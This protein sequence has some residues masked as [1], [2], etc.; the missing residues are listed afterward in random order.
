MISLTSLSL[1]VLFLI[2]G[3]PI[4]ISMGLAATLVIVLSDLPVLVVSQRMVNALDSSPLLAV[5]LFI[6]AASLFDAAGITNHIFDFTKLL[7]GRIRGGLGYVTVLANLIFSGISGAAL[8]DIGGLG[9]VQI[10][11]MREQGYKD[12]F[13]A[14]ITMAAATIG[15]IF[16]PSIP[17]IIYATAAEISAIKLLIAGVVPAILIAAFL[18]LEIA[19]IAKVKGLPREEGTI[20]DGNW[21]R[22]A[23]IAGP[24]LLAPIILIGGLI[25]GYFGP[26]EVA[27][28][29]V[30]YAV[31]LGVFVYRRLNWTNFIDAATRT[32]RATASILFI[33][34]CAAVFAWVFTVEQVPVMVGEM[35]LGVS[36]N[37]YVL[38]AIVN[39]ALLIIG[40]VMES[41]AAILILAP[42]LAPAMALAGVDP[43]QLGLVVVLN[44]MIGLMTPPVGMSLYMVSVVA[45]TPVEKVLRG[46]LPFLFP[47]LLSLVVVS[48]VPAVS[49]WLPNLLFN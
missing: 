35:L 20:G 25:S 5:P 14:G 6:F 30:F 18:M 29:T 32:V 15:P 27:A 19:I 16:P 48:M 1:F 40:M 23:A 42:I 8:A 7:V 26:T 31:L 28:I 43:V 49:T 39:V 37:P 38:L 17:L 4:A 47:L 21:K 34:G 44:L 3:V 33:V 46:S 41:I 9:A 10:R 45:G 24:A 13:S 12:E 36:S 22:T 11:M 2:L